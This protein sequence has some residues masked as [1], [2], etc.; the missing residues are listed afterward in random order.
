MK[1]LSILAL[2]ALTGSLLLGGHL[3]LVFC[4]LDLPLLG[5]PVL[6]VVLADDE[7][8]RRTRFRFALVLLRG[9]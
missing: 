6:L 2:L 5:E 4:R 1:L 8:I 9:F 3:F 7:G